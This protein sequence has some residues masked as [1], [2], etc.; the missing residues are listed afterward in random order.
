MSMDGDPRLQTEAGHIGRSL[1]H[2]PGNGLGETGTGAEVV[3]DGR[4]TVEEGGA[5]MEARD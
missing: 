3:D 2:R 5:E 4:K 1:N